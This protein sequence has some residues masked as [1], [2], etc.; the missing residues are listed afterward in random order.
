MLLANLANRVKLG[1]KLLVVGR[2]DGGGRGAGKLLSEWGEP[3][4]KLDSARCCSLYQVILTQTQSNFVLD[5]YLQPFSIEVGGVEL[6]LASLPGVFSHGQLDEGTQLLLGNCSDVPDGKL[7][8]FACG[9]GVIG[10]FLAKHNPNAEVTLSDINALALYSAK[11]SATLNK[12]NV[13]IVPSNGL[14]A[15][16]K[17]YQAIYTNP[18]FHQGVKTDYL[19]TRTFIEHVSQHLT[20]Q[21]MLM[22]VANRFL[23]YPNQLGQQMKLSD[24][25]VK[26]NKFSLYQ[27][28]KH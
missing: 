27:A 19:V 9:C 13:N 5:D 18:P 6:L 7:L 10:C 23:S 2:N 14:Q 3:V 24:E 15:L 21:G 25:S 17:N 12:L 20:M 26:T 8:D 1:G 22:M 16:A 4:I 28:Y 11:I